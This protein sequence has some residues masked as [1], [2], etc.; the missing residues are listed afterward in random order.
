MENNWLNI[1]LEPLTPQSYYNTVSE[2]FNL[3]GDY[4][5][6]RYEEAKTLYE[7]ENPGE[8]FPPPEITGIELAGS[9]ISNLST[10]YEIAATLSPRILQEKT[11]L[12][13]LLITND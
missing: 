6:E 2:Y 9:F 1:E 12:E 3:W 11:L 7:E 13:N 8:A 4:T 10:M 5:K